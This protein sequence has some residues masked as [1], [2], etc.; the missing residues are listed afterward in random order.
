[1]IESKVSKFGMLLDFDIILFHFFTARNF[2]R[3]N[4]GCMVRIQ[5]FYMPFS[6]CTHNK[7]DFLRYLMMIRLR[8]DGF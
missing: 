2:I 8:V 7:N 4:Q 5:G 1:M 6:V 3:A